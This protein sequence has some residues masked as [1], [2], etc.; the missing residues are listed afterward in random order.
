M[1]SKKLSLFCLFFVVP[2]FGP[3]VS[4][5]LQDMTAIQPRAGGTCQN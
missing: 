3:T 4:M 2:M 5:K 1:L